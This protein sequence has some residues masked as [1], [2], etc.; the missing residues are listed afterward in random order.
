MSNEL[1]YVIFSTRAGRVGILGT[2]NGLCRTTLPQDSDRAVYRLLGDTLKGA[3]EAPERFTTIIERL[4][5]YY[6]G[7]RTDFPDKLDFGGATAFQQAVWRAAQLIAFGETRS[8][9]WVAARAG[10]AGAARAAGQALSRN[11]LPVI[12]PCHRVLAA[13]G[14]LGGFT[15]GLKVKEY[16]LRLEAKAMT[17]G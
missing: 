10:K 2:E 17:N 15:G 9:A 11:P 16:L 14:G 3:G 4:Q 13:D 8:Y 5:A 1:Y 6:S 12:V 7:Y